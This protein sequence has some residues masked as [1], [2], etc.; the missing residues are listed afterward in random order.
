V[1][2]E[3]AAV[4]VTEVEE[5]EAEAEAAEVEAEAMIVVV[6]VEVFVDE[7]AEELAVEEALLPSVFSSWCCPIPF[8][9]FRLT[10]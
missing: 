8:D 6:E 10:C 1:G 5:A 9:L 7:A 3:V 2:E 4:E